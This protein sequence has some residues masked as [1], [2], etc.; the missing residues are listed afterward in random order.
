MVAYAR[1]HG[2]RLVKVEETSMFFDTYDSLKGEMVS[3]LAPDGSCNETLRPPLDDPQVCQIYRQMRLL[4]IYDRKA[5]SLQRQGRFGTYAQMEGQE[6]SLVASTYPLQ[7]QDW[8][9]TSY[10]ETGAMWLHGVP[11]KLLSLYWMGNEFGSH[12]PEGVRVLPM[13]IPVGSHPLHAV[14][15]AYAGKYRRDDSIAITYFGDGATSEGDVHEAMNLAGVYNLPCVFFCQNNQYAISVPRHEQTASPTIAQKA[16]AYGFPG[17]QVD[18][19]DI[20]AVY[21]VVLEAVERARSGQ[22]PSLIEA[23]TYRFG[24]HTTADDPT[25]YRDDAEVEEWRPRDPLLRLQ[26]YLEDGGQWSADWEQQLVETCTAE[27]EQAMEEAAAVPPPPPQDV[28][29]YMYA[30]MTPPLIEQEAS[31]L[32]SLQREG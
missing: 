8:M 9:V 19:N 12:M 25:K 14:G 18:G 29:R 30:D 13:S 16:L 17:V 7:P 4:R 6:A 24:A 32:A 21:A 28:F 1:A 31:L 15:L 11:L 23:Y 2:L 3:I 20:F 22:G 10:R 5:V 27:V 26:R